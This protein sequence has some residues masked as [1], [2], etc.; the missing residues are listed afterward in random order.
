MTPFSKERPRVTRNGTYMNTKYKQRR[1]LLKA[2]Y[3]AS[4]YRQTDF[5]HKP[6]H[7]ELNFYFKIPKS[8]TKKMKMNPD[9]KRIVKDID[10]MI[11]GVLD[12]LN[13]VAWNDDRDIVS[14]K[15]TKSYSIDGDSICMR[16]RES[17]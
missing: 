16:I 17:E 5:K 14:V 13:G 15:A 9:R 4:T 2:L 10:N 8:W 3:L 12:S 6:L 11:G 7:V 1:E